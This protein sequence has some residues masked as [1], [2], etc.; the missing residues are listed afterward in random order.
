MPSRDTEIRACTPAALHNRYTFARPVIIHQISLGKH[1]E[2][3]GGAV[4]QG[5]AEH[6]RE[7]G[8]PTMR[9]SPKIFSH[10][11]DIIRTLVHSSINA[12]YQIALVRT[13]SPKGSEKAGRTSL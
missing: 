7:T 10:L 1:S 2:R 11:Q 5:T 6:T 9:I 8:Q 3:T 4:S 12:S 13:Q